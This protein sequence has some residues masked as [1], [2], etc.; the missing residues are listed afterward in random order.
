TVGGA[1]TCLAVLRDGVTVHDGRGDG[2]TDYF[3]IDKPDIR[4]TGT[5]D[6]SVITALAAAPDRDA[7]AKV[8]GGVGP[9]LLVPTPATVEQHAFPE[10]LNGHSV[11][12]SPDGK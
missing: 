12:F 7:V 10:T 9:L 6:G 4:G 1:V 2:A 5:N 8:G 3:W 11:A